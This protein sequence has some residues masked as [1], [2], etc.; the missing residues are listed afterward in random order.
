MARPG[1]SR[2]TGRTF[3]SSARRDGTGQVRSDRNCTELWLQLCRAWVSKYKMKL[4]LVRSNLSSPLPLSLSPTSRHNEKTENSR[5]EVL[6]TLAWHVRIF[7]FMTQ[8]RI[9]WFHSVLGKS[10]V[11]REIS[12]FF[13]LPWE[14]CLIS[15]ADVS[16]VKEKVLAARQPRVCCLFRGGGDW[17]SSL[18][19]ELQYKLYIFAD[20]IEIS[21][22]GPGL[23]THAIKKLL[24]CNL[25]PVWPPPPPQTGTGSYRSDSVTGYRNIWGKTDFH[26]KH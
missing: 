5:L 12:E 13:C 8:N 22:R 16:V 2:R 26:V 3:T 20:S 10:S 19:A 21:Q 11:I 6:L 4:I 24:S 15:A 9:Q 17:V 23:R 7:H 25:Q 14:K 1:Q 18:A